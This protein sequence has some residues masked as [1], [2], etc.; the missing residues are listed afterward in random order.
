MNPY[1][2]F[3]VLQ[4][5]F[6][7][8]LC[9]LRLPRVGGFWE[10]S[11]VATMVLL[12]LAAWGAY[13]ED[14]ALQDLGGEV[15][16]VVVMFGIVFSLCTAMAQFA[17]KTSPWAAIFC[18]SLGYTAQN[19]ATSA[20]LLA[21]DFAGDE[22]AVSTVALIWVAY[23]VTVVVCDRLLFCR[24]SSLEKAVTNERRMI[25]FFV[26]VIV[27]AIGLSATVNSYDDLGPKYEASN[28]MLRAC[29]VLVCALVLLAEWELVVNKQLQIDG[30]VA[31]RLGEERVHQMELSRETMDAIN[32]KCHDMR[33]QIR[34]L[35]REGGIVDSAVIGD[36]ERQIDIYD[37][38]V[39]TGNETLDTVLT[40]KA[41]LCQARGITLSCIVDGEALDFLPRSEVCSLFGNVLD[42][43]IEASSQVEDPARRL[44]TLDVH[45]RGGLVSISA[46][47][48][49]EGEVLMEDRQLPASRRGEGHGFGMRSIERT[50]EGWGGSVSASAEDGVFRL[51]I[52]MPMPR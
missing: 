41:L 43:A 17:G 18:C 33:H 16:V 9:V 13:A 42:N 51:N 36:M 38:M 10:R 29:H 48:Y 28:R 25:L 4:I 11:A 7:C 32:M 50:A 15:S 49:F 37:S 12:A 14:L 2:V 30:A 45:A 26:L 40:D 20:G 35:A 19:L 8:W 1:L 47:N 46:E 52:V 27:L 3:V 21:A 6:C 22:G 31:K 5:W 23:A 44:I 39:R 34:T 24:I